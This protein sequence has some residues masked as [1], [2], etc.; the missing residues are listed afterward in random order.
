[1]KILLRF[2]GDPRN[3]DQRKRYNT[4]EQRRAD[5]YLSMYLAR[6]RRQAAIL[7]GQINTPY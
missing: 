7:R 3:T 6:V 2:L 4:I 5:A 1:M